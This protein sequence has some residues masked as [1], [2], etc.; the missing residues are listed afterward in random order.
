MIPAPYHN[1]LK[2]VN[3]S[4]LQASRLVLPDAGVESGAISIR[5]LLQPVLLCA[6]LAF[7]P[8]SDYEYASKVSP[9]NT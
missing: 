5:K 3:S 4:F 6:R 9:M 8:V 1:V 2:E 7:D